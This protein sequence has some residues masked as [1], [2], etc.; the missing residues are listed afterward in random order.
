M[1]VV[2]GSPAWR[3]AEPA[4]PAGLTCAVALA[5]AGGGSTVE[6]VGRI[7]D[8][9]TGDALLIGLA[10]AGVGHVAVLRDPAQPTS[11]HLSLPDPEPSELVGEEPGQGRSSAT[12]RPGPPLQPADV[13]LGLS[14][15]TSFRVLVV[16][17]DAP[18]EVLPAC[19]DGAAFA[20]AH[21]LVLVT[22]QGATPDGLPAAATVLAAPVDDEGAFAALV[23]AYAAAVDAGTEPAEAFRAAAPS[24]GWAASDPGDPA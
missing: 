24:S 16:S 7:G 19:V 20:G 5:A 12:V 11:I 10:Q 23:G 8:D 4:G 17:N 18:P 21:L 2:V 9:P 1:I 14:Y 6:V 22:G 15:L 13:A 3:S